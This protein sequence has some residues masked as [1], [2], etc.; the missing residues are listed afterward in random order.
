MAGK[1]IKAPPIFSEGDDYLAWKNDISVWELFTDLAAPKR[2]PAVYLSLVGK[3]RE[4]VRE[5]DVATLAV[6]G[7]VKVITDKLDGIYLK[8]ANTQ[9]YMNFKEFYEYRRSSGET[10]NQFIVQFEKL[11]TKITMY[12]MTLPTGVKAFFLLQAANFTE[13]NEKL[14]RATI[15]ELNYDNMKEKCKKIFGDCTTE[16]NNASPQIKEEVF[17]GAVGHSGGGWN[18]NRSG[19]AGNNNTRRG[20]LSVIQQ[21]ILRTTVRIDKVAGKID[22][23]IQIHIDVV[24]SEFISR[25]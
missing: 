5:V 6:A 20:V 8:D 22:E 24:L 13:D 4:A 17:Y 15:G 7:G 1:S 16:E 21:S 12:D 3:T 18:R 2:G 9:A 10:F 23:L 11:Y 14:A 25:C 19:A